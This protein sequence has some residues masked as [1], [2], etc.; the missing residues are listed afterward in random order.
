MHFYIISTLTLSILNYI[1]ENITFTI[2]LL[3]FAI[4]RSYFKSRPTIVK[5]SLN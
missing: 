4:K 2:V 3:R 1:I 5:T